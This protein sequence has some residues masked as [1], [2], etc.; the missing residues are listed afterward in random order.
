MCCV[1]RCCHLT[2]MKCKNFVWKQKL[3]HRDRIM[4]S[5]FTFFNQFSSRTK[6]DTCMVDI[7]PNHKKPKFESLSLSRTLT[8]RKTATQWLSTLTDKRTF[9]LMKNSMYA[10]TSS[11]V[12][13][14]WST[15]QHFMCAAQMIRTCR[16]KASLRHEEIALDSL[17]FAWGSTLTH[18]ACTKQGHES[19]DWMTAMPYFRNSACTEK[20]LVTR[21]GA[22]FMSQQE[23]H[24][25][26]ARNCN[27]TTL[28]KSARAAFADLSKSHACLTKSHTCEVLPLQNTNTAHFQCKTAMPCC[29]P[30][31]PNNPW[32]GLR[33]SCAR[34]PGKAWWCWPV[35]RQFGWVQKL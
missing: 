14:E 10:R 8:K 17:S 26:I 22:I 11:P 20:S 27:K 33:R 6:S 5:I 13:C 7:S 9:Q 28:C 35:H 19:K 2:A 15:V 25:T 4:S 34:C 29:S 1:E 30:A 21:I 16:Q 18:T 31:A 23:L 12:K 3:S 24:M 32:E